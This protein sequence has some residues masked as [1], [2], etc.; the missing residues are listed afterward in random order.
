ME[1]LELKAHFPTKNND[2]LLSQG[3]Q[4]KPDAPEVKYNVTNTTG[5]KGLHFCALLNG[6]LWASGG[7]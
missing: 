2:I 3:V 1:S 7:A 5:R 4:R 6:F